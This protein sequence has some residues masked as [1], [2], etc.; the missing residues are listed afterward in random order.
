MTKKHIIIITI[1][2]TALAAVMIA[3][4]FLW[5]CGGNRKTPDY[6]MQL[7]I[8]VAWNPHSIADD[9]VRAMDFSS[10][11]TQITLLNH[12]G[13][14]GSRGHNAVYANSRNA[15]LDDE[16][17]LLSTSLSAFHAAYEMGFADSSHTP[18]DW[19]C[20]LLAYSPEFDDYYGLFMPTSY[21]RRDDVESFILSAIEKQTFALFLEEKGLQNVET[22]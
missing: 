5:D 16:I 12:A 2:C 7:T 3:T 13:A 22:T 14:H 10:T 11:H 1:I 18:E 21:S 20:W 8:T 4:V 15:A 17:H 19:T 6:T 9:M